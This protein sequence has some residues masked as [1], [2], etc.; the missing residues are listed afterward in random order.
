MSQLKPP[1]SS[2]GKNLFVP[3]VDATLPGGMDMLRIY[4]DEDLRSL[5]SKLWG[6]KEP[7]YQFRDTPRIKGPRRPH[8]PDQIGID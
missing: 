7:T 4:D 2:L 8:G 1:S 6:I 5:P 3:K